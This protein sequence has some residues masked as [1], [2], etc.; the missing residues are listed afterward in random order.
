MQPFYF[1]DAAEK[2]SFHHGHVNTVHIGAQY[3]HVHDGKLQIRLFWFRLYLAED[4]KSVV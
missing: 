2:Y 3:L 1:I 4:R